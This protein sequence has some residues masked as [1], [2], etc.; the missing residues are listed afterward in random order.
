MQMELSSPDR[1]FPKI[2]VN[3]KRIVLSP[4]QLLKAKGIVNARGSSK[5]KILNMI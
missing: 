2:K 1:L 5:R 4:L 3:I